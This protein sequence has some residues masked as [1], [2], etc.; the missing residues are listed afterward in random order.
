M[1]E[2]RKLKDKKV[3]GAFLIG[4]FFVIQVCI[5]F[6]F[7]TTKEYQNSIIFESLFAGMIGLILLEKFIDKRRRKINRILRKLGLIP[8]PTEASMFVMALTALILLLTTGDVWSE[9]FY[10]L[11]HDSRGKSGL[12]FVYICIGMFLSIYHAFS[13]KEKKPWEIQMLKWFSVVTLAV[14]TISTAVFIYTTKQPA[15]LVFTIWN[16]IQVFA[17]VFLSGKR[18]VGEYVLLPKRNALPL[19]LVLG[20]SVVIIVLFVERIF[21]T[22]W[23]IAFSS[24]LIVWSLIASYLPYDRK[25]VVLKSS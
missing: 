11:E 14:I 13:T 8:K 3:A 4:I 1:D 15:Y 23:S 5:I 24:V 6:Y 7:F 16:C 2:V 12:V 19:E 18:Y 10:V 17:L 9:M 21:D 25:P 22:H 20:V